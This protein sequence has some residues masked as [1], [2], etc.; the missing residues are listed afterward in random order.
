[1]DMGCNYT[2]ALQ[3]LTAVT[4]QKWDILLTNTL[5]KILSFENSSKRY[6]LIV[7]PSHGGSFEYKDCFPKCSSKPTMVQAHTE[8]NGK[9]ITIL[10]QWVIENIPF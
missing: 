4:P 9:E 7:K 2:T 10:K 8:I 6:F 3:I 5:E 1:M